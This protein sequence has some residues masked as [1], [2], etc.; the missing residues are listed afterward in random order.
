[1]RIVPLLVVALLFIPGWAHALDCSDAQ[2]QAVEAASELAHRANRLRQCA[3]NEDT[4]DDCG[5]EFRR[6]EGAHPTTN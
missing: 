3:E 1:M 5:Q 2:E 4:A 6:V